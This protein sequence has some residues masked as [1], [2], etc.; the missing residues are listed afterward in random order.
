MKKAIQIDL[1]CPLNA[2]NILMLKVT[3]QII[4]FMGCLISRAYSNGKKARNKNR[5]EKTLLLPVKDL[6]GV[7]KS[8]IANKLKFINAKIAVIFAIIRIFLLSHLI[9]LIQIKK[10]IT[11][12][13]WPKTITPRIV[14]P[15]MRRAI[16]YIAIRIAELINIPSSFLGKRWFL[17][18]FTK[19][20][21]EDTDS[22]IT[23]DDKPTSLMLESKEVLKLDATSK[24][25]KAIT[26]IPGNL[27]EWSNIVIPPC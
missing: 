16:K 23:I 6:K 3:N 17:A 2:S 27:T 7:A 13:S 22:N 1:A 14:I 25:P 5:A 11:K 18:K 10:I 8:L 4:L 24:K 9:R 15:S 12:T 20:I 21:R 26:A 19:R